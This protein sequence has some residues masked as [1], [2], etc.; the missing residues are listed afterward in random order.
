[1]LRNPVWERMDDLSLVFAMAMF[2]VA[3]SMYAYDLYMR[4]HA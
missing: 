1:M 3:V 4:R 2:V